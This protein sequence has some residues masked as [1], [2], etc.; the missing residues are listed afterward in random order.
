M[1]LSLSIDD[2]PT[3]TSDELALWAET[4]TAT[5]HFAKDILIL[6]PDKWLLVPDGP[7]HVSAGAGL[8]ANPQA[9]GVF[10]LF[11]AN[12]GAKAAILYEAGAT[13]ELDQAWV[14]GASEENVHDI[15]GCLRQ[16]GFIN[17]DYSQRRFL[18][19]NLFGAPV[20]SLLAL[21][22]LPVAAAFLLHCRIAAPDHFSA[23]VSGRHLGRGGT[24]LNDI[25]VSFIKEVK[26]SI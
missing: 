11:D 10:S 3:L 14:L 19:A 16:G 23:L 18:A 15:L 2:K 21:Y 12:S 25:I 9:R 24:A 22:Q 7:L 5:L 17:R 6:Q 13:G 26:Q 1:G 8:T 20:S 4:Q